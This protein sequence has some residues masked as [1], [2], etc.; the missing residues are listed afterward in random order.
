MPQNLKGDQPAK[1]S[2]NSIENLF[3]REQY[4]RYIKEYAIQDYR[5]LELFTKM[6]YFTRL[7]ERYFYPQN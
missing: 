4:L 3:D 6:T 1:Q 2:Y 5:Y 7:V